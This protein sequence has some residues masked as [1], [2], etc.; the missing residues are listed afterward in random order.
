MLSDFKECNS[1]QWQIN[2]LNAQTIKLIMS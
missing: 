2:S 1:C